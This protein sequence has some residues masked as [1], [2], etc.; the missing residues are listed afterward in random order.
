MSMKVR[1]NLLKLRF[2]KLLIITKVLKK[3]KKPQ[4]KKI[5]N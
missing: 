1:L 3:N 5:S 4:N 2:K